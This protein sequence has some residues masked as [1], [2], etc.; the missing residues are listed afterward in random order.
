MTESANIA[1]VNIAKDDNEDNDIVEA[2]VHIN[3]SEPDADFDVD[4]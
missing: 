3:D 1:S 4:W 2:D